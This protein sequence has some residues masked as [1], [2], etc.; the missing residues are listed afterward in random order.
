MYRFLFVPVAL[1]KMYQRERHRA[2]GPH[3]AN[4]LQR[5]EKRKVH[6]G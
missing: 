6:K 2:K 3:G 5:K 4:F 1:L